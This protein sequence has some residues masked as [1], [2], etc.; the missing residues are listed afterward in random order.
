MTE[1]GVVSAPASCR[2]RGLTKASPSAENCSKSEENS[3]LE[4]L[5]LF[6]WIDQCLLLTMSSWSCIVADKLSQTVHQNHKKQ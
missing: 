3:N 4:K 6:D 5:V 2:R 1:E